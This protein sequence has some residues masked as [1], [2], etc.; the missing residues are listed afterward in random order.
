MIYPICEDNASYTAHDLVHCDA[1]G[2]H[3]IYYYGERGNQCTKC[4]ADLCDAHV[5]RCDGC[6]D[7]LCQKHLSAQMFNEQEVYL[8]DY[9]S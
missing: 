6:D 7:V 4:S 1:R 5:M 8:C 2:C 9:C 3:D